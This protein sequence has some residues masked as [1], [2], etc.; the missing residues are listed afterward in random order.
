[1]Q[2]R[3][4][5]KATTHRAREARESRRH[6]CRQECVSFRNAVSRRQE[7]VNGRRTSRATIGSLPA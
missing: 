1:M 4:G 6:P 2:K 7:T 3:G 5:K